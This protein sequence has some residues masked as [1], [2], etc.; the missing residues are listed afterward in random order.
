MI[1]LSDC[2]CIH[3]HTASWTYLL[4]NLIMITR[5]SQPYYYRLLIMMYDLMMT[6][7]IE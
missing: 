6:V 3:F 1:E 7:N 5:V 2:D 4:D